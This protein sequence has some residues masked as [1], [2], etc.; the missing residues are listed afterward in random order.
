M[1]KM[2]RLSITLL[3]FII[4]SGGPADAR[5]LEPSDREVSAKSRLL[6]AHHEFVAVT[7]K[8][9]AEGM[10]K[11]IAD[12]YVVTGADGQKA[13]KA[14]AVAAVRGNGGGVVMEES[15][16]EARLV[17]GAG[18][19]MGLIKWTAGTG[20]HEV[21]GKV[22]FTEVWRNQGGRWELVAAQATTV[23]GR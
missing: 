11:L 19:V 22:R 17:G 16:V 5:I 21:S 4:G 2:I 10:A 9:D 8:G 23:Q 12:D 14:K 18:I 7:A 3:A 1:T 6:R 20:E 13:D 15:D